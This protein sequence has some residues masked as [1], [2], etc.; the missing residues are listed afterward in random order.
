MGQF[1]DIAASFVTLVSEYAGKIE[2]AK[3]KAIGM[4]NKVE[5]EEEFRKRRRMELTARIAEKRSELDRL[6]AQHEALCKVAAE[7]SAIMDQI[8]STS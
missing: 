1:Q 3:L 5:G 4:R 7:Q 2:E 6:S 8:N